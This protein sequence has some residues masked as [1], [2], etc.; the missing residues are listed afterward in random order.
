MRDLAMSVAGLKQLLDQETSFIHELEAYSN[1]L[2]LK[3]NT[4]ESFIDEVRSKKIEWEQ[5]AEEYVAHPLNSFSLIRR[6]HE[7]WRYFELYMSEPV[8]K[9]HTDNVKRLSKEMAP[10]HVDLD[11]AMMAIIRLQYYYELD[12]ANLI[13]GLINGRQYNSQLTVLEAFSMA[14]F[15]IRQRLHEYA[16]NWFKESLKLYDNIKNYELCELVY[17]L[18]ASKVYGDYANLL[19]YKGYN[20]DALNLL[21]KVADLNVDLWL[22][23]RPVEESAFYINASPQFIK[24]SRS[25]VQTGCADQFPASTKFTCHFQRD[26][27]HFLRLAP[28]KVETLSL[29]P[30]VVIF[31]DVIYDREIQ[32]LKSIELS[33]LRHDRSENPKNSMKYVTLEKKKN[34]VLNYRIKD[35]TGMQIGRDKDFLL[36]NYG[37]GGHIKLHL[38][39]Q[40]LELVDSVTSIIFFLSDVTQGGATVFP[41]LS[42]SVKPIKGT[43]L[44]WHNMNNKL[45][46]DYRTE[47]TSCPVLVG[48]K[49]TLVKWLH[50]GTQVLS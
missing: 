9:V 36:M 37:L 16:I 45:S 17:N 29:D 43:A 14:Q 42:I 3:I 28:L 50:G 41:N 34:D 47:H 49:W 1:A 40:P 27:S 25:P 30:Y 18:T 24:D 44:L 48:S 12:A 2:Q 46:D 11:D 26:F 10:R 6:M 19:L 35:M 39:E 32:E 20:V 4:I 23:R 38:D 33:T 31:H 15:C 21:N 5:N 13:N 8:G 22:T 7:D